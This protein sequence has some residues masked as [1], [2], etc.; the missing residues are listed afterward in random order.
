MLPG[1]K[2]SPLKKFADERG[3][4]AEVMRKDWEIFEDEILQANFSV[5][6]PG[7]VRAW[8]RHSRGQVDYFLVLKGAIKICAYDEKSKKLVEIISTGENLQIV[9]I[10]GYYWHGF[11]VL[12]DE[13][14]YLVYFT[15]KLYDYNN[16]DE[17]RRPWNDPEIVPMEING[18]SDELRC[19]KSWDWFYPPHK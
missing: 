9:R 12:G 5:T 15:N 11:K 10:P 17:E 13:K 3:F 6:Y 7:I 1:V 18:R 16:P 2:I 14:A 4:F 8:H 19:G